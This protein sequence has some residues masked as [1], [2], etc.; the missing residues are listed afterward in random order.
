VDAFYDALVAV[1]LAYADSLRGLGDRG[2]DTE[3]VLTVLVGQGYPPDRVLVNL[4]LTQLARQGYVRTDGPAGGP[5]VV[6]DILVPGLQRL[7]GSA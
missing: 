7:R 4:Y 3:A 6:R 5:L 1:L 2:I